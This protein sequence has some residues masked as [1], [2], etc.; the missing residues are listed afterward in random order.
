MKQKL[1]QKKFWSKENV[2]QKIK[3]KKIKVQTN[4]E[5]KKFWARKSGSKKF[6]SK[7]RIWLGLAQGVPRP[8]TLELGG[9]QRAY[10]TA[11]IY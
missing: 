11:A 5:S 8:I 2:V 10:C 6:K 4:F 7:Q 3:V 1:S 9:S